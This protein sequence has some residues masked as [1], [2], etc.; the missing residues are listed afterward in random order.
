MKIVIKENVETK[1]TITSEDVKSGYIF[2]IL[3]SGSIGKKVIALKLMNNQTV[4]LTYSSG[5]SWFDLLDDESW[6][7][8]PVKILGKITEITVDPNQE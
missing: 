1:P 2:E 8:S 3:H 5:N 6:A 4:L 7:D